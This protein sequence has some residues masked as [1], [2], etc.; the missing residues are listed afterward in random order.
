MFELL[1]SERSGIFYFRVRLEDGSVVLTSEGY[2]SKNSSKDAIHS[3]IMN[4]P[5]E[6]R[7]VV[8]I[9]SNDKFYFNIKAANGKILATSRIYDS[10]EKMEAHMRTMRNSVVLNISDLTS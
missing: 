4:A 2:K 6:N 9:A 3:L 10:E 8:N 7:Y 1:K 5:E